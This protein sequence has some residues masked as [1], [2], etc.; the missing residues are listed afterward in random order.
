MAYYDN[1]AYDF[2]TFAP[3]KRELPQERTFEPKIVRAPKKS[4]KQQKQE[5]KAYHYKF[6]KVIAVALVLF[7]L[8]GSRIYLQVSLTEKT[9]ALD[10]YNADIKIAQS[11]NV[12]LNSK[13]NEIM[14][15]DT[16]EQIAVKELHMVKR[17][18]SQIRYI[19]VNSVD[20][21]TDGVR[22]GG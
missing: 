3:K 1:S 11:E 15:L 20:N 2:D 10:Q 21:Y 22:T 12:A 18:A 5:K 7:V 17:D 16:V 14:S 9:R 13:L 19:E 6:A 4:Y 8:L